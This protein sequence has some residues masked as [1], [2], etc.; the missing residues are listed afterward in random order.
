MKHLDAYYNP[1]SV[2]AGKH[3]NSGLI[4]LPPSLRHAPSWGYIFLWNVQDLPPVLVSLCL[5]GSTEDAAPMDFNLRKRRG[6]GWKALHPIAPHNQYTLERN[7]GLHIFWHAVPVAEA[8]S[9]LTQTAEQLGA[10]FRKRCQSV[11]VMELKLLQVLQRSWTLAT[12]HPARVPRT[13]VAVDC[14]CCK[15]LRGAKALKDLCSNVWS[16]AS[17]HP[18]MVPMVG[19]IL[20]R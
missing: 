16:L 17:H 18:A 19:W 8:N 9:K 10:F 12:Q 1:R 14:E 3:G 11:A 15:I 20:R 4:V 7:K 13:L 2:V 6:Q 5:A